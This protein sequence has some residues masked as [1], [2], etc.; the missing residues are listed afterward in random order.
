MLLLVTYYCKIPCR[1]SETSVSHIPPSSH[2]QIRLETEKKTWVSGKKFDFL[3]FFWNSHITGA[4]QAAVLRR[5][6]LPGQE[7]LFSRKEF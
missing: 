7:R 3:W 6:A 5:A 1:P 2:Q 4:I